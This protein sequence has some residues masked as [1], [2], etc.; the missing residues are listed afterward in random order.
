M[1][2]CN[3][4]REYIEAKRIRESYIRAITT[5][6][7]AK[8]K[9]IEM[10][11]PKMILNHDGTITR[12]YDEITQ[13]KLNRIDVELKLVEDFYKNKYKK[14]FTPNTNAISKTIGSVFNAI[15]SKD[16]L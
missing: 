1:D 3:S 9:I 7:N 10:S 4:Q 13:A 6:I 5:F 2:T 12:E 14:Y 11:L 8:V 16:L 15:P